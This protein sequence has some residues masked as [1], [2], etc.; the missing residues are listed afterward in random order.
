MPNQ[1]VIDNLK[2]FEKRQRK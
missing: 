2:K 1:K